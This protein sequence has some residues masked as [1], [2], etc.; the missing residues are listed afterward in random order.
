ME[1]ILIGIVAPAIVDTINKDVTDSKLR[2]MFALIICGALGVFVNVP[3]LRYETPSD[4]LASMALVIATA[5][6]TY[7]MLYENSQMQSIIKTGD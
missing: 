4:V 1:Q 5:Q 7:K 6:T 2:F 3:K